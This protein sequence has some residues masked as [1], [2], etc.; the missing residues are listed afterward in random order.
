MDQVHPPDFESQF[1]ADVYHGLTSQPKKVGSKYFYDEKGD[2]LFQA[3][4]HLPEYYLTGK[5]FEILQDNKH[6]ISEIFATETGFDL[7]ELGAGDGKKTK[8]LLRHFLNEDLNFKYIPVDI[9][10]NVL[11][12]LDRSLEK[13]IPNL[14]V[15]PQQGT[16]TEVLARLNE[17]RH[18]K[19]VILF[20]GSNI[21]NFLE[22]EAI[23]FLTKISKTMG[24]DDLLLVGIDQKK[25]PAKI[26]AAYNDSSGVT[27]AFNKNLLVRINRELD[28]NFDPDT[29]LHWPMYDPETGITKSFLV[30]QKE[31]EIEVNSLN[32]KVHFRQWE[33]IHTEISMK[34]DDE[35]MARIAAAAGL[36]MS[37]SFN[38][39]DSYFKNY[40]F[41]K[42][43]I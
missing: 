13:E 40:I 27:A 11:E 10:Q 39:K 17:Y 36:K 41:K 16:Y 30:S 20:L 31:Q 24:H 26:L 37:N 6:A 23:H 33:T 3:I 14:D 4:M 43:Q 35:G 42:A 18:R 38:D 32:L 9:S 2:E 12:I 28:A 15:E 19:K 7:I 22:Q 21:G 5:E 1:A 25:D 29:F 8:I 34:Y